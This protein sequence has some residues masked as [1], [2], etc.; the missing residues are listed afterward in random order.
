LEPET[1]NYW[2]LKPSSFTSLITL[3]SYEKNPNY[4]SNYQH[5]S[6]RKLKFFSNTFRGGKR[7]KKAPQRV[8]PCEAEKE[9]EKR[10]CYTMTL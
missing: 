7:A 8:V 6:R 5:F 9:F 1:L 4:A 3:Q 10:S 2:N